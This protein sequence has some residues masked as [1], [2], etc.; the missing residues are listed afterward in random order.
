MD[1]SNIVNLRYAGN[2]TSAAPGPAEPGGP[3]GAGA[4]YGGGG[5]SGTGAAGGPAQGGQPEAE[6]G[7]PYIGPAVVATTRGEI[8]VTAELFSR[9]GPG[10]TSTWSGQLE[11]PPGVN[12]FAVATSPCVLRLPDGREGTVVPGDV[13]VGTGVIPVTGRGEPPFGPS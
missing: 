10:G 7:R 8:P 9:P 6:P 11:A 13:T 3:A 2:G 1:D 5:R 12:L 4:A